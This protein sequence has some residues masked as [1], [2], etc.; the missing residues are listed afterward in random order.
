MERGEE[1]HKGGDQ[2][3]GKNTEKGGVHDDVTTLWRYRNVCII[4]IFIISIIIINSLCKDSGPLRVNT[5]LCHSTQYS[6]LEEIN[7]IFK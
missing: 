5:V 1:L 2:G 3:K 6:L 4:I 7:N